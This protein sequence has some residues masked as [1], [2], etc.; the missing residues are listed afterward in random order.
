MTEISEREDRKNGSEEI[1]LKSQRKTILRNGRPESPHRNGLFT[2][3]TINGQRF[4]PWH[5][6][7]NFPK[8][9]KQDLNSFQRIKKKKQQR[10]E[11]WNGI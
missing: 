4:I 3:G 9:S 7:E 11:N 10:T 1:T 6:T 5:S 8:R 2:T